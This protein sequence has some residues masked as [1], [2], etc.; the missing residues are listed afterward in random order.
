VVDGRLA[1]LREVWH[2]HFMARTSPAQ[3]PPADNSQPATQGDLRRLQ[4]DLELRIDTRFNEVRDHFDA[5]VENILE[6]LTGANADELSSL[7]DARKDHEE[8]LQVLEQ[9]QGL[10]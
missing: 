7:R 10:R 9:H 6:T 5:A 1:K 3:E 2:A 4:H 8:R